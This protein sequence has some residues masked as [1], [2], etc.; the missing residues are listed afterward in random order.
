MGQ[1]PPCIIDIEMR[2]PMLYNSTVT[3]TR[4]ESRVASCHSKSKSEKLP[5][6]STSSAC[7]PT[8][9]TLTGRTRFVYGLLNTRFVSLHVCRHL[10]YIDLWLIKCYF[11]VSVFV[12]LLLLYISGS[13]KIFR[14]WLFSKKSSAQHWWPLT[15][16]TTYLAT[17]VLHGWWRGENETLRWRCTGK[18]T[19]STRLTKHGSRM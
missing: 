19:N 15:G 18:S 12:C 17:R 11:S 16:N 9:T 14:K 4:Q 3:G 5:F 13:C 2:F 10:W 1:G 6:R 7:S 8:N